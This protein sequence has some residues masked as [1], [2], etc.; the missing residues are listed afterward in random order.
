MELFWIIWRFTLPFATDCDFNLENL[1]LKLILKIVMLK[2]QSAMSVKLLTNVFDDCRGDRRIISMTS[3][4]VSLNRF[5]E[6]FLVAYVTPWVWDRKSFQTNIISPGGRQ[7]WR[8]RIIFFL[9]IPY[10]SF[11]W[12][13][14]RFSSCIGA[15]IK[16]ESRGSLVY[17]VQAYL[18]R[19]KPSEQRCQKVFTISSG[20]ARHRSVYVYIT[21]KRSRVCKPYTI[22]A[23]RK[24]VR[25]SMV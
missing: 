20:C 12:N 16:G 11:V 2:R 22:L 3:T 18:A 8:H 6:A 15:G 4:V 23:V 25:A 14:T 5:R 24:Y 13:V 19:R 1:S 17:M 21:V 7:R 9:K 10:C